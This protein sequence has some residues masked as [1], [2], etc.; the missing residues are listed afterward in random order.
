[1]KLSSP[2][3]TKGFT[4]IELLIVITIIGILAVALV[5][6]ISQG[7]ARARDVTR[8][9]DLGNI[10][11]AL[12][13]YNSDTGTY[14]G[15]FGS[16]ECISDTGGATA[17]NTLISTYMQ[18]GSVPGDP[19]SQSTVSCSSTAGGYSYIPISSTS[20]I[21]SANLEADTAVGENIYCTDPVKVEKI[22]NL[23][24]NLCTTSSSN[25]N[26]SYGL[27]Q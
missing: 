12:S 25:P 22:A 6:R 5:P 15:S 1:M 10:Q 23:P 2:R 11:T 13:L 16:A 3:L 7:P 17:A 14:P 4:L 9:A 8:K 19:S 24:A 21:L 26:A 18:G 20:Y 27:F